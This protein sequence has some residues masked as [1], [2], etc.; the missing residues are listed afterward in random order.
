MQLFLKHRT[1]LAFWF[2]MNVTFLGF[3][4]ELLKGTV[5]DQQKQALAFASVVFKDSLSSKKI[6]VG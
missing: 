1:F 5:V 3:G 4:Q 6:I 2:F